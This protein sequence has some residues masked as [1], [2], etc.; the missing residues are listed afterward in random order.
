[1]S[2]DVDISEENSRHLRGRVQLEEV[3]YITHELVNDLKFLSCSL[4][5]H[6]YIRA[7]FK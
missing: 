5:R 3:S 7:D 4:T 1:M 6:M 2:R